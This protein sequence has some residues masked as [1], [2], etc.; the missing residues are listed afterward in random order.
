[1]VIS[2]GLYGGRKVNAPKSQK[3][4]PMSD[5]VRTA[6]FNALGDL[7][8]QI[9]LDAY[10]GS[11]AVG[12]EALSHKAA[13]VVMIEPAEDALKT[14]KRNLNELGIGWGYM[15]QKTTIENWLAHNNE[16]AFDVIIAD[17]PYDQLKPEV[18]EQLALR[19]I[20]KGLMVVSHTSRLSVPV[21]ENT[22]LVKSKKYG[23]STLSFYRRA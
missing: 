1:L 19:L 23:D 4:R 7:D 21:I 14:I 18:M 8:G 9:V 2:S 5:K 6:L 15:V 11:G 16:P 12:I 17:P 13:S 20:D 3:T 22:K 10:S